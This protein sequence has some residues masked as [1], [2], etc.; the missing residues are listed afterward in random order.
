LERKKIIEIYNQGPDAVVDLVNRIIDTFTREISDLKEIIKN[1]E[2]RIKNLEDRL[3]KNSSN[4]S[5]PPS[6]D[7]FKKPVKNSRKKTNRKSGGQKGHKGHKLEMVSNPDETVR[8]TVD[9][10]KKCGTDLKNKKKDEKKRQVFDI[11][12]L[13]IFVTEYIAESIICPCC[14]EL[15][16]NKFPDYVNHPVGYG[17]NFRSLI[18]YL[19]QYQFIPYERTV[20]FV[21]DI[22]NH[23]FSEGTIY[24]IVKD[25]YNKLE[26]TE[27][28]IKEKITNEGVVNFD[29]SGGYCDKIRHW[30]HVASTVALT[31]FG[32]H[33]NRGRKAMD[34]INILPKFKGKA[35][36]DFYPSYFT[37][38]M[39]HILCN[40][41]LLREL[42]FLHE[43]KNQKWALDLEKLILCIKSDVDKEKEN[44]DKNCLSKYKQRKYNELFDEIISNG[45]RKNPK[46]KGQPGK[47]GRTAQTTS[48][49]LLE[50]LDEWKASYLAFMTD[51]SIPFDNNQSERDVRMLKL[52]QKISGTFRSLKGAEIFC[53]IRGYISTARKNNIGIFQALK[54]VFNGNPETIVKN[55]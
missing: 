23:P 16:E 37:Y 6:T 26:S 20:Q 47:R 49:N 45:L 34:E 21:S 18:V 4:S 33:K 15:N 41:H 42:K 50:R 46:N 19:N 31:Y 43:E 29:E 35:V 38:D 55:C 40:S 13:N 36:H 51:F 7:G 12:P 14:N 22:F 9:N 52:Q 10:C 3:S 39:E 25:C 44:P 5:K 24:N 8:I 27:E 2:C 30:F 48:R 54:M 28:I 53:R 11:P 17:V 32:F 1:Q